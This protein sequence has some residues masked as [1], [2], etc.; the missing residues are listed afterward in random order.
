MNAM[1]KKTHI[2]IYVIKFCIIVIAFSGCIQPSTKDT[3]KEYSSRTDGPRDIRVYQTQDGKVRLTVIKNTNPKDFGVKGLTDEIKYH[4]SN[5]RDVAFE[6]PLKPYDL[7]GHKAISAS[8]IWTTKSG[9]TSGIPT[10]YI[11]VIAYPERNMLMT[12]RSNGKGSAQG[13]GTTQEEHYKMVK[14]FKI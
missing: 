1:I 5:L 3:L 7:D 6:K 8:V 4:I 14:D 2:F 9:V 13:D 10:D 11:T 12:I